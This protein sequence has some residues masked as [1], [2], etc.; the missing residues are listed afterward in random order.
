MRAGTVFRVRSTHPRVWSRLI[1]DG[2]L[3]K[4]EDFVAKPKE[5]EPTK[6]IPKEVP[7]EAPVEKQEAEPKKASKKKSTKKEK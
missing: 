5:E 7:T 6:V 2:S 1:N 3:V 4:Q